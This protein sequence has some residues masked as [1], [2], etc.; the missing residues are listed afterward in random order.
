LE[1]R[2]VELVAS[3]EL[4]DFREE[5]RTW[6]EKNVPA[7]RR[8]QTSGPEVR[9]Y[10]AE[11]QRRQFE[12]GWAG[13]NWPT[14]YGGRGLSLIQQVIWYEEVVRARAPGPGVFAVSFAHAG[15]TLML[16]GS[17]QQKEVHLPMMLTGEAAWCQSFSEPS[18]GSDLA[19]LRTRG[20][21]D[22][23][24]LVVS[25]SKIWT[26]FAQWCDFGELLV[27]TDSSV[28]KH[29]GISWVIADM[30]LPGIDIRPIE[31]FDGF[32]HYSEVFYDEVRIPLTNVVGGLNNGWTVALATLAAERGPAFLDERL[33]YVD[34]VDELIDH[35]RQT[36]AIADQSISD[37][38][39]EARAAAAALR[40]MAYYQVSSS[41]SGE[42][43]HA[44][45]T[46]VRAFYVELQTS[47]TR[48]AVDILGVESLQWHPWT[49][50]WLTAFS[51]PIAG[52]TKDIQR[53]ILGERV[54]GL[55]R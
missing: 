49:Q 20:V 12:G 32:P 55:P 27:R 14:E 9:E 7:E 43:P 44:E 16:W 42:M 38:L 46:A 13:I 47:I 25:G 41:R 52:G 15:P 2:F 21:V 31:C 48:L 11:W 35:A 29:Q 50:R 34:F 36:G 28:P 1:E 40:S 45:T 33:E 54:L 24:D 39:A 51:V 30:T 26:S 17:A 53:N 19:S 23:D 37:R 18:S 3:A 4:N 6:L 22:G 10:D 8:P 5:A